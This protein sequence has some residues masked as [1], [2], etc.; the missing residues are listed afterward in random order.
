MDITGQETGTTEV[1]VGAIYVQSDNKNNSGDDTGDSTET[2]RVT[3]EQKINNGELLP[4]Q[5]FLLLEGKAESR[6]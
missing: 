3:D 2:S 4:T 6:E 1:E 5:G